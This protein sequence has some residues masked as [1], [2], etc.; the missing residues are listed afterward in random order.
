MNY[1]KLEQ[2]CAET[3]LAYAETMASAYVTEPEDYSAAVT[4][5]IARTLELHLNRPINL[6][7]LY[8]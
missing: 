5:L 6:E 4:A 1:E 8:K 2:T 7:N 3:L